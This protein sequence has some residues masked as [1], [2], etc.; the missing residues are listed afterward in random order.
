[1]LIVVALAGVVGVAAAAAVGLLEIT[2]FTDLFVV[3]GEVFCSDASVLLLCVVVIAVVANVV[4]VTGASVAGSGAVAG[5]VVVIVI[6]VV[7]VVSGV[8]VVLI[9]SVE[10][11]VVELLLLFACVKLPLITF[12]GN[13]FGLIIST[14]L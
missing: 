2:L 10:L 1:M 12:R 3:M 7:V 6:G 4:D 9:V 11:F 14:E 5:I 13:G 8:V